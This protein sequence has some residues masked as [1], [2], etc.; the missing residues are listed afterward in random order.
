MGNRG[1]KAV[2]APPQRLDGNRAK[3]SF[4]VPRDGHKADPA[5]ANPT[6]IPVEPPQLTAQESPKDSRLAKNLLPA[7]EKPKIHTEKRKVP[8]VEPETHQTMAEPPSKRAKRTDSP[9]IPDRNDAPKRPTDRDTRDSET[10]SSHRDRDRNPRG[11]HR[12]G[13][14][15]D[16]RRYRSRSRERNDRRRDRSRSKERERLR[17]GLRERDGHGRRDRER[18]RSRSRDRYRSRRGNPSPFSFRV[19][20]SNEF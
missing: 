4:A 13:P 19:H 20:M 5:K 9:T 2:Q 10:R 6:Q 17:D 14:G 8:P 7:L 11:D 1:L 16:E 18:S 12:Q 3:V 15:R